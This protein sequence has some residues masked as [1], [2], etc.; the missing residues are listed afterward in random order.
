MIT[1]PNVFRI[2]F[3][4]I[5]VCLPVV[6]CSARSS[7]SRLT[8]SQHGSSKAD[9]D[10]QDTSD[11]ALRLARLLRDQGRYEAAMGVYAQLSKRAKMTP[12]ELL[13]YANVAALVCSPRDTLPLFIRAEKKLTEETDTDLSPE[14]QAELYTGLGRARMSVGQYGLAQQS[15][16]KAL[17][18]APE[19]VAA[20]NA[21]GVLLDAQGN[22]EEARKMLTRANE[23]APSDERI[24]NNLALSYLSS[25]DSKQAIRLFQQANSI[26][27]SPSVKLNL[28]FTFY[29]V[30]QNARASSSLQEF[31]P[32][33]QSEEFITLFDGMKQRVEIGD[34]TVSE[35]LLRAA[36]KLIEIHPP[37]DTD[38]KG[39][40][41][42]TLNSDL[43]KTNQ[44]TAAS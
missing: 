22:H 7:S 39:T 8:L 25:N 9:K 33:A 17:E 32:M 43:G 37:T 20:L 31:M 34:S 38:N 28:A 14:V 4:L 13:E 30:D 19:K 21:M 35:E 24:L 10:S 5:L 12:L 41:P 26:S 29:M 36:D 42:G 3:L 40:A 23:L 15:L 16:E 44:A 18:A 1:S 2:A 27:D 6:G 11:S